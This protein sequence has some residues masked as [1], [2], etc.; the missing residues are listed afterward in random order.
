[1]TGLDFPERYNAAAD[2]LDS[3]LEAGRADH[4]AIRTTG[5]TDLTYAK[6]AEGANR[7]GNA[8][9]GLGLEPENRVLMA[10]LDSPEFATTFFGAIKIGAVPI[11][12]NTNLKPQD[13]A[14]VINDSRAKVAVVSGQIA[15]QLRA[16]RKDLPHLKQLVV[17]GEAG[18]GEQ[19]FADL[20]AAA[21]ANLDPADT[22]RDD[23]CFWLYSSGTTGFPK[24]VVHLQHD[25]RVC[26]ELY[27]KPILNISEKDVTFSVAKLY[28]AYGLGNAL[29]FPFAVGATTVLLDGPPAPAHVLQ[30]VKHFKPTIY[31]AVPTSYANT[32]AADPEV[33][34]EADFESV[35]VCVSAGEP[36]S[37]SIVHHWKTRTGRDIL[38][39]IGST[40]CC[41]IFVSNR[42]GD[43]HPDCSGKVV[44]G[45]EVKVVD[46]HGDEAPDGEVGNLLVKGDSTCA[47]YWNQHER[48]KKT[49][50]GE[51]ITTGDKYIRDADGYL[52]YQ[53]RTDDML[54]VG[55]IWVSPV[56]VESCINSHDAVLESAV[57][58][59]ADQNHLVHAE[60]HVVVKPGRQPSVELEEE[61]RAYVRER[62]AHFKCPRDFRFVDSLPKTATGKIQRFKLRAPAREPAS[63]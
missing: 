61:L 35:R 26:V 1:M 38:D 56:E 23:M 49:I 41:H 55:G 25:M 53:G 34:A 58:G 52:Y 33:W 7:A 43:V 37:G 51:W 17:V 21:E 60:A 31:Y 12:V 16:V 3:N 45:Y 10:V 2:L 27:A 15:D 50:Q 48:T 57:V 14:Y 36:L 5:G 46:E 20:T 6:V 47:Y 11:P 59:V 19:S 22:S 4:V 42:Q 29:Y 9:R 63:A 18:K 8:L 39:G 28:F 32:L 62:L 40:E 24:G 44:P 30:V 54:K 13:F